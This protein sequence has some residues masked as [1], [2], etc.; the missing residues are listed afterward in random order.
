MIL[1]HRTAVRIRV[2]MLM[3]GPVVRPGFLFEARA[4]DEAKEAATRVRE[5][6]SS[7][8]ELRSV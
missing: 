8:A 3:S 7:G 6:R 1:S 4:G 2:G 5:D